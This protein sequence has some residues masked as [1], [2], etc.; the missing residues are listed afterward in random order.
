MTW[1]GHTNPEDRILACLP[2]LLPLTVSTL[3]GVF[4]FQQFPPLIF[5]IR[6]IS[7]LAPLA[8]GLP[9]LVIFFL[10]YILVVRNSQLKHFLR[11]NTM[12]ALLVDM[13]LSIISLLFDL[14]SRGINLGSGSTI[15]FFVS[16]ISST[17]FLGTF[18]IVFYAWYMIFQGKYPE[19]PILSDAAYYH[20]QD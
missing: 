11:F 17:L 13:G 4:L 14:I 20:T 10:L 2:Y 5:L 12:Q 7:P 15:E 3:F 6:I 8:I 16:T 9:G 18:T 1:R 19:M